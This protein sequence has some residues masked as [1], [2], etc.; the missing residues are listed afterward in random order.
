M[1]TFPQGN[2]WGGVV[3]TPVT[4]APKQFTALEEFAR[5]SKTD[6]YAS[7]LNIHLYTAGM[8]LSLN[9]IVYTKPEQYPKIFKPFM[10]IRPQLRNTMR[11]TTLSDIS[12]ELADG[13]PK[14]F[15]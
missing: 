3:I 15:R 2:I 6:P 8:S 4:T 9:S 7:L 10:D 13:V 14:G 1:L 11:I 12:Q 5:A